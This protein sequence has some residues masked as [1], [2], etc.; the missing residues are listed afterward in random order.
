M[1]EK[2]IKIFEVICIA[3][4]IVL[5]VIIGRMLY[6]KYKLNNSYKMVQSL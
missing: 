5:I 4:I 2:N 3:I 6:I 1:K